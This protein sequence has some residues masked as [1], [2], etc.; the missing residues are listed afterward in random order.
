MRCIVSQ[1]ISV[2]DPVETGRITTGEKQDAAE[3][4]KE[5]WNITASIQGRDR[6]KANMLVTGAFYRVVHCL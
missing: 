5:Q 6:R 3:P 1:K 4:S 2:M